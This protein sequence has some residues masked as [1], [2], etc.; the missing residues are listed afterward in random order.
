MPSHHRIQRHLAQAGS[1]LLALSLPLGA[2]AQAPALPAASSPASAP[3]PV[4]A[5]KDMGTSCEQAVRELLANKGNASVDVKFNGAPAAPKRTSSDEPVVLRGSGSWRAAGGEQRTF[6]YTC[7]ADPRSGEA[8]GMVMRDTSP[9]SAKAPAATNLEPDLSQLSPAVCESAV[10]ATLKKRWPRVTEI[11]FEAATRSV[12]QTTPNNAELRGR[13]RALTEPGSPHR[14]F[15][16]E[17]TFD[18][19]DGRLLGSKLSS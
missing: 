2:A 14:L 9:A 7:N 11:S 4:T 19:R 18:T 6:D 5:G 15:G 16:F 3:P 17:C 12:K 8:V 13:G 10:A 1:L